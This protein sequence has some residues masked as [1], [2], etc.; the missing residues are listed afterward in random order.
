MTALHDSETTPQFWEPVTFKV[1]NRVRVRL[2]GEC[3]LEH[4]QDG[5]AHRRGHID[6]GHAPEEDGAIGTVL[7][8]RD[9]PSTDWV[10]AQG[11]C[12]RVE[13]DDL[14]VIKGHP[15]SGSYYAAA[16]LELLEA[17]S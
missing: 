6:R 14:V 17:A 13:F 10:A 16:E 11:H 9:S 4:Q 3:Q 8:Y 1:G 12:I 5:P 2:S 7:A 15:Y